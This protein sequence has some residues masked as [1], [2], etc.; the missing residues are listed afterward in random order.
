MSTRSSHAR[1]YYFRRT[2]QIKTVF[3]GLFYSAI[4][5]TGLI[6]TAVAMSTLYWVD[7]YSLLRLWKRPPVRKRGRSVD[8]LPLIYDT[9]VTSFRYTLPLHY[10]VTGYCFYRLPSRD[11]VI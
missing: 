8:M 5:P 3:V 6:V 9:S 11:T 2:A 1:F 10:T 4:V 7:K